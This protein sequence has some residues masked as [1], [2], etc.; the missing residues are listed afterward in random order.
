MTRGELRSS[1]VDG[2]RLDDTM[3]LDRKIGGLARGAGGLQS[4][5]ADHA[6]LGGS[7]MRVGH[8]PRITQETVENNAPRNYVQPIDITWPSQSCR[9]H[10]DYLKFLCDFETGEPQPTFGGPKPGRTSS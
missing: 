4:R 3:R 9:A 10:H 8:C 7:K 6:D 1:E 2:L 5:N